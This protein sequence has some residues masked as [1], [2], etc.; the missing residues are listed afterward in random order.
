MTP[1]VVV[2]AYGQRAQTALETGLL[3]GLG[4]EVRHLSGL[5]AVA[6]PEL[7][8]ADAVMVTVQPVGD[9]LLASLPACQLIAR[10][11]T[12]LDSIDL[13]AA[14]RRGILVTN[15]ADYSVDEVST[16]A[17]T[18]LLAWARRLPQYLDAVRGG[19]WNSA[20]SGPIRRLRGQT[21]GLAGFGRIGAA[22]A[23]KGLGLGLRVL[24]YD[25]FRPDAEIAA[26][27]AQPA[28]WPAVLA[29]ADYL[30]LHVPLTPETAGLIDAGALAVMK[31][32]A[33]LIN[34]ARG[35]LVDEAALAEAIRS[36][37]IAGAALDV[38][39]HEPP[40]A[41]DPLLTDPRVLVTPHTGWYSQEAQ[42]DV[43]VRACEDV[44]RVLSGQPARSPVNTP[45]TTEAAGPA[46]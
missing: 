5:P 34:T 33:V 30:S 40:A 41:D 27:G 14:A 25:R 35:G 39:R 32:S 2:I 18:L 20:G 43:V 24:A 8:D 46:A 36:G 17:I 7:A 16:H 10:V 44:Q 31:P 15:V 3:E 21:L 4:Y 42:R 13:D 45:V 38:L 37:S 28:G 1:R 23:A 22:T 6:G 26:A 12:G 11:G 29:E 9:G 19:S